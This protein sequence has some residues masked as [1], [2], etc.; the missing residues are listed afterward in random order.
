VL[1]VWLG[2]VKFCHREWVCCTTHFQNGKEIAREDAFAIGA[3]CT[4][5]AG[6]APTTY[7]CTSGL[8]PK[9]RFFAPLA[10]VTQGS[11]HYSTMVLAILWVCGSHWHSNVMV[12]ALGNKLDFCRSQQGVG[13]DIFSVLALRISMWVTYS[14]QDSVQRLL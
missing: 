14:P 4:L 8:P 7:R 12:G 10:F 6:I 5:P 2:S 11:N 3:F 1:T 9:T 13:V